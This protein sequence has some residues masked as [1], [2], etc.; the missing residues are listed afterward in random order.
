MESLKRRYDVCL[1]GY[2]HYCEQIQKTRDP[3]YNKKL[4]ECM[5]KAMEL[6][7]QIEKTA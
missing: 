5:S 1:A 4:N 7:R 3:Y 2:I 6:K